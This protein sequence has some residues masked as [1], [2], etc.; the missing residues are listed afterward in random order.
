ME[1][2]ELTADF[3]R[4][5]RVLVTGHTGFKGGWLSVWLQMLGAEVTGFSLAPPTTPSFFETVGVARSVV[6][7][8]GDIR[9]GA[10][11]AATAATA[12]PDIMFHMAAQSL[13]RPSYADPV[14]TFATNVMGTVN[15]LEAARNVSSLR[16]IIVVT[17]D[18]CYENTGSGRDFRESDPLGG[19]DPYSSSKA[20]TELVTGAYRD[21][22]FARIS[23][24]KVAV[25]SAR[26]GNV[27]G[28]GDWAVDRLV[29]DTIRAFS[30]ACPIHLRYPG[31]TRP[32]Q[33]VLDP[34][35][36]YLLLAERLYADAGYGEA[37]NFG[38]AS[39]HVTTVASVVEALAR[40][41]GDNM[42][43]EQDQ[44]DNP[45]EARLLSIDASKARERLGWSTRLE[46]ARAVEWTVDWYR[47]ARDGADMRDFTV[48][49][50]RR[51]AAE[52][53]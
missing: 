20:C 49:Q 47:A 34:L 14:T 25:A 46:L 35:N 24:R 43:W 22:F 37:W 7:V 18:K 12:A 48:S 27:I 15:V 42:K 38:P 10:L 1:N 23:E 31:A 33:H 16:A 13:V 41:W 40:K 51:F 36:G 3:W 17:S 50:I 9:D 21:S 2:M 5:K 30:Q 8:I 53:S 44:A 6:S 11:F 28:G 19:H 4:G 26:A 32:W 45:P 52:A 29:P 39:D